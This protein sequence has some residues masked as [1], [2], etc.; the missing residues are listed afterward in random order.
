[1]IVLTTFPADRDPVPLATALVDEHLAACVNVLPS[2]R[3]IYRWEGKVE[4]ASEHQLVIKTRAD[5]VD[6]VKTRLAS[7]HPY[8]VPEMLVLPIIDGAA[9][10]LAWLQANA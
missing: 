3:S 8:D 4:E 5:R 2:M 10:Y 6:A 7:L 1:V 9:S